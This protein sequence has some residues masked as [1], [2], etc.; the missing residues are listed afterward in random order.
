MIWKKLG[1]IFAPDHQ[2]SWMQTHASPPF[3]YHVG[4]SIYRIYFSTRD[5]QNR[6]SVAYVEIDMKNPLE[7]LS[8]ADKPVI[9]IGEDGLFD[10]HGAS[11]SQIIE[12]ENKHYLYYLGWNLG[13]TTPFRNA[14]GLAI[15]DSAH[16]TYTKYSLAPVLDRHHVDP[17]TISVPW[18]RI[19]NNL[20]RMWYGSSLAWE[21][22]GYDICHVIKYA[23]S[24][25]GIN[26]QRSGQ[27]HI[28]LL[29]GESGVARPCV[30]RREDGY[31][32][33]YSRRIGRKVTC[34]IGYAFS[35]DGHNW[36]RRDDEAGIT[37]SESGWDSEM[38]EYPCIFTFEEQL[39]MLYNGNNF[40]R[41]G[42]GIAVAE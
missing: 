27:I 12:H 6:S 1:H 16:G 2:Y 8:I 22:N 9:S 40:G 4:G 10:D 23:Q 36:Q 19:E 35:E 5:D 28:D 15:S 20:W 39:Y 41:T 30:V 21:K 24:T 33:W 11:I 37:V 38:V 14:I 3:P 31:H 34:R 26:W 25:D 18:V 13:V 7:V 17:F 42:F 32:M 29:E